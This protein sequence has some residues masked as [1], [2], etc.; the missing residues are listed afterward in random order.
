[1]CYHI[2]ERPDDSREKRRQSVQP[3]ERFLVDARHDNPHTPF[4][5]SND[6]T[7]LAE[8]SDVRTVDG[9][10]FH[11]EIACDRFL[12]IKNHGITTGQ[13]SFGLYFSGPGCKRF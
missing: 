6:V 2:A 4:I 1:V 3:Q 8:S 10:P 13:R 11:E 7:D 12:M 5:I 9:A